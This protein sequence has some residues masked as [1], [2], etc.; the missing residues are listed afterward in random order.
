MNPDSGPLWARLAED[1][2]FII[3]GALPLVWLCWQALRYPTPRRIGAESELVRTLYT[4]ES[5]S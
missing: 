4:C 2:L 5:G 3:G 1:A